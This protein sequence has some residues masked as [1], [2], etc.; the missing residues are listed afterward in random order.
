[1]IHGLYPDTFASPQVDIYPWPSREQFADAFMNLRLTDDDYQRDLK[2]MSNAEVIQ[3]M[4]NL[5]PDAALNYQYAMALNNTK[6]YNQGGYP[7]VNLFN[8]IAWAQFVQA[9]K[10]GKFKKKK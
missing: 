7:S 5:P 6:L 1:M 3:R 9:W 8:P 2:Q 10:S 4:E